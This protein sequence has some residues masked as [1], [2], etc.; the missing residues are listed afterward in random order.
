MANLFK[1]GLDH[2]EENSSVMPLLEILR[3]TFTVVE[4]LEEAIKEKQGDKGLDEVNAKSAMVMKFS[5]DNRDL[6]PVQNLLIL[7][8]M[9]LSYYLALVT[10]IGMDSE[11]KK[12]GVKK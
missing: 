7:E 5:M 12:V 4:S 10:S 2:M 11:N 6:T 9:R 3:Q 1:I 8:K